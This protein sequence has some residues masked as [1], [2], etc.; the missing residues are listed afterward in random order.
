MAEKFIFEFDAVGLDKVIAKVESF[1]DSLRGLES[2]G[3][4]GGLER[5]TREFEAGTARS[6]QRVQ[7]LRSQIEAI[8]NIINLSGAGLPTRLTKDFLESVGG[9]P[10][11]TSGTVGADDQAALKAAGQQRIVALKEEEVRLDQLLLNSAQQQAEVTQREANLAA[12]TN[13]LEATR[14]D[15]LADIRGLQPGGNRLQELIVARENNLL[16]RQTELRAQL[17]EQ[18]IRFAQVVPQEA[19]IL[20]SREVQL[21]Q[22]LTNANTALLKAKRDVART[23]SQAQKAGLGGQAGGFEATSAEQTEALL[24]QRQIQD[25]M[26]A[27]REQ[28][29]T[30]LRNITILEIQRAKNLAQMAAIES[31]GEDLSK[32]ASEVLNRLRT[33]SELITQFSTSTDV[34]RDV[35]GPDIHESV[36]QL[37][38]ELASFEGVDLELISPEDEER[39]TTAT[40]LA[41]ELREEIE[42]FPDEGIPIKL[43]EDELIESFTLLNRLLLGAARDFGRRFTA[44]IQFALSGALLFGVQKL[45]REFF[46]AAVEVE[47]TFADI[48]SSLSFDI[49]AERGTAEFERQLESVRRQVL[50]I[51]DDFNVLPTE[52]NQAAFVMIS[53]FTEVE[54]AM[55]ATRAQVLA[56]KI[57]TIDQAEALRSLTAVAE[58]YAVTLFNVANQREREIQQALLY[59]KALDLA[60]TIQQQ[61]G[62]SVEDTLEGTAGLAELF[63]TLGFSIED[64]FALV[65]TTVLKTGQTGQTVSDRLGRAFA[66]FTSSQVRDELLKTA[67]AFP[68]FLLTSADFFDSGR[69][70]LFRI[71]DQFQDLDRSLQNRIAEIIGGRRETAF[72]SALLSGASEGLVDKVFG[73]FEDA[74]GAAENRLVFLLATVSGTIE[75]IATEFQTLAQNLQQLGLITPIKVLLRIL[76][77]TLKL[78]NALSEGAIK[79]GVALNKIRIPF[80]DFGL[81]SA[82]KFLIAMLTA[83]AALKTLLT[84]IKLIANVRGAQT[85]LDIFR[86]VLGSQ[87]PG[88]GAGQIGARA[89]VAFGVTGLIAR[90]KDASGAS[91]KFGTAIRTL[92]IAPLGA[93]AR[94]ITAV[95]L[96]FSLLAAQLFITT[97]ATAGATAAENGLTLSR[98]RGSI[99]AGILAL[100]AKGISGIFASLGGVLAK[101]GG[102]LGGFAVGLAELLGLFLLFRIVLGTISAIIERVTGDSPAEE[103]KLREEEL[104]SEAETL[105]L[106]PDPVGIRLQAA[107]ERFDDLND[108]VFKFFAR[109]EQSAREVGLFFLGLEGVNFPGTT[110]SEQREFRRARVELQFA[111]VAQ[112]TADLKTMNKILEEADEIVAPE[113]TTAQAAVISILAQLEALDPDQKIPVEVLDFID[114]QIRGVQLIMDGIAPRIIEWGEILT[115]EEIDAAISKVQSDLSIGFLTPFVARSRIKDVID[116][117]KR[118]ER[119]AEAFDKQEEAENARR[120]Q[121]QG[122]QVLFTIFNQEFANREKLIS[123]LGDDRTRLAALL[124]IAVDKMEQAREEGDFGPE[125][126][127]DLSDEMRRIER[128]LNSSILGEAVARAQFEVDRAKT[129]AERQ[130][131]YRELIKAIKAEQA[132]AERLREAFT[133]SSGFDFETA[134]AEEQRLTQVVQSAADDRLRQNILRARNATLANKSSLDEI[135]AIAAS[136]AVARVELAFLVSQGADRQEQLEAARKVSDAITQQRLAESDRRAAFFRLTAGT[137]DQI[138]RAQADL[139]ASL[140]RLAA[141]TAANAADTKAGYEAELA[142]L[143]A[144]ERLTDLALRLSDLQ[145]RV[146]SDL[147]DSFEQALLDVRA[148]QESLRRAT[149][150]IEKLEAEQR[151][152]E[153]EANAQRA[154]YDQRISDL[155]FLFQTDQIGKS[156]YI[157]ALRELQKGI[158]RTSKQGEDLWRQIELQILGLM[159]Q[160]NQA[161]N[162][163]TEIRLP[164]LFEVRRDLAADALGVNYQ[165]NR[166][167]EIN[168]FVSDDLDLASVID[169][170][171]STFGGSIDVAAARNSTGGAQIT[172]GAF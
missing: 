15:L 131:A 107:E 104:T 59:V 118:A 97:G 4:G 95:R 35:F 109:L 88:S 56:T 152:A 16:Q 48:S 153:A 102:F 103:Q 11:V 101:V 45:A 8:Q 7:E 43:S 90:L 144:R 10:G 65:A 127:R 139:R 115:P 138:A 17:E 143:Q 68:E 121:A 73:T 165:D 6:I 27:A 145:R 21:T 52:V 69:T 32:G 3:A 72:V 148:A 23:E 38:Q 66:Q 160:A 19:A 120:Q 157:A 164:T 142:V 13:R 50:Q 98:I 136:V 170:I 116:E 82:L 119:V 117:A 83:G 30:Q 172:I 130:A 151:L 92:F 54:A 163:P 140:D 71:I 42:S 159:D 37:E 25:D 162:I 124:R 167:Q 126:Y 62:I 134:A 39:L 154:F 76:E 100:R 36:A 57:A 123:E 22:R 146:N 141:I 60:T 110:G 80:T 113:F 79:L 78:V 147:T 105:G 51:A 125:F 135:A 166:E 1:R 149:G 2:E 58:A 114:R 168:I 158:D 14:V 41:R 129:F 81:G 74:A 75:G 49:S 161:F 64:T 108:T 70:A 34:L 61:F 67:N 93:A 33:I 94:L 53:R 150:A 87:V 137:G 122:A 85:F 31:G 155:D 20:L 99:T 96:R 28:E 5:F 44:T 86:G 9:I 156:T 133:D 106:E 128:E 77:G 40:V 18:L 91:A 55:I 12:F 132:E 84:S 29:E 169:Q 89:G 46:Q 24:K 111:Q 26:N 63:R 171:E 47:R 112:L